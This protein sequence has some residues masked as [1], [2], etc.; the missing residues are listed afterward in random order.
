[1]TTSLYEIIF[2]NGGKTGH[3]IGWG[4]DAVDAAKQLGINELDIIEAIKLHG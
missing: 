1:M 2:D 4:N 3:K